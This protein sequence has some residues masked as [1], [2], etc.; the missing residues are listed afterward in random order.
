VKDS[1]RRR[2]KDETVIDKVLEL[3]AV[4][5]KLKHDLDSLKKEKNDVS[6]AVKDKKKADKTDK[7]EAEVARSKEITV[8]IDL[9]EKETVE[10]ES[11]I[12]KL[13][14]TIGNIVMD[15]V[16][17]SKDE[18]NNVVVSKWGEPRMI[19]IDGI[20]PGKLHHHEIMQI[21]DIVDF[22]RGQKIAGHRGFF[23]K[24]YGVLLN[25]ALIN[26]GL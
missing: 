23:L 1:I 24:G 25:Q 7:C 15:D 26:Y 20:T 19:D 18:A 22:E 8:A 2:F 9:K 5:R 6:K 3:D 12:N 13:Y 16:P 21:L 10:T 4:W 14:G 11:Q 17:V